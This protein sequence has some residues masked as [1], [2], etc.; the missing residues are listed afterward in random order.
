MIVR[1]PPRFADWLL[2]HLG[3]T[4]GNPA[5]AG[6]LLEEFRNGR[7]RAWYWRQTLMVIA[8]GIHRNAAA[9]RTYLAATLAG[10]AV[11]VLLA[12]AFWSRQFPPRLHGLGWILVV[13]VAYIAAQVFWAEAKDRLFGEPNLRLLLATAGSPHR[14]LA[15]ILVSCETCFVY[16]FCYSFVAMFCSS[17]PL[18]DLASQECVWLAIA[19]LTPL[20]SVPRPRPPKP[21]E[22]AAP[23]AQPSVFEPHWNWLC[24]PPQVTLLLDDGRAIPLRHDCAVESLFVSGDALLAVFLLRRAPTRESLR[25][26]IWLAGARN[27]AGR[28][29]DPTRTLPLADFVPLLDAASAPST[30]RFFCDPPHQSRWQRLTRHLRRRAD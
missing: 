19:A 30:E 18:D 8:H 15:T 27:H 25:R 17:L 7:S 14:R 1:N 13:I 2:D 22:P 29:V 21:A 3:Y 9:S 12:L 11:Q 23:A 10:F 5:L 20:V 16:L 28:G 24:D 4:G 6:D 26:A